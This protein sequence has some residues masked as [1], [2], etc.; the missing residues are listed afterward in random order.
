M[1]SRDALALIGRL[2][3]RWL[4]RRRLQILVILGVI[5]LSAATTGL[6]P[7]V[8]NEAFDALGAKDMAAVLYLPWLVIAVVALKAATLYAQTATTTRFGTGLETDVQNAL[9]GHLVE[10]DIAR[11]AGES[12]AALAQ[13][14]TTD[15]SL[16]RDAAARA[17]TN[18]IRDL[19]TL[20]S[21]FGAMIWLDWQLSLVALVVMPAAVLPVARIG[22]RLRR[23]SRTTQVEVGAMAALV[24]ESLAS[25]RVVKSYALEP[26]L[27]QR[28]AG[29]FDRIRRLKVRASDQRGLVEPILELLGGVA[30]AAILFFIGWRIASGGATIGQFTGFVSALLIAAQPLRGLGSLN[31]AIQEG[32]ASVQRVFDVLDEPPAIT[33]RPGAT[34]LVVGGGTVRFRS[35]GFTYPDGTRALDGFDLEAPGGKVTAIVGRS[36]AGKSTLFG[37]VGRLYDVT[38]GAIEID[39]RDIRDVTI[40]SLRRAVALVPQ[41]PVLFNDTLAANIR[42]GRPEASEDELRAAA[43]AAIVDGF[44]AT[45]PNG[46]ET[47]VGD[48][49][50]RLSGG[51]RQR[52][53]LAR[54]FLKDAP[55]LLLDEA[56]S[57]LD[58]ESEHL[59][60]DAMQRLA[61]GRTTLVIAHRLSTIRSADRIAV[62]D[63]G[64]VVEF[65]D[66]RT[67]I[68]AD[69]L[70]AHLHRLQFADADV[71]AEAITEGADPPA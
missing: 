69:G 39:G 56:T 63:A 37:L 3:Q 28:A 2:W 30:V 33:D 66:H 21:V 46:L 36:G 45:L 17:A 19:L 60:R 61:K 34:E 62:V 4:H 40:A 13:R 1:F 20:V 52:V 42:F 5:A 10:A 26:Y 12:P 24:S 9:F 65:G 14:F 22:R 38:E 25:A 18:L 41:E 16:V 71:V 32:L 7:L 35:V 50:M 8:I 48:A 64:R 47:S 44:A 43:A 53:T 23:V 59:V 31:A 55:I 15:V 70:Y 29:M 51:Q 54:A 6:Y 67:L 11:L 49:G 58:T 27:K 57:A 68:A